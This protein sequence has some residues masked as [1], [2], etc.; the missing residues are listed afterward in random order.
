M[1]KEK[2]NL[3]VLI[4]GNPILFM[5]LFGVWVPVGGVV[6]FVWYLTKHVFN[7]EVLLELSF[8]AWMLFTVFMV[9][10]FQIVYYN[11]NIEGLCLSAA[12]VLV[13]VR[14]AYCLFYKGD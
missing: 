4:L 1:K 6:W 13:W 11:V 10:I 7:T 5:L 14:W 3:A 8:I 12:G 9:I 2:K